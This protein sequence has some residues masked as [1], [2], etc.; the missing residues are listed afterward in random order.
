VLNKK[1]LTMM[2][3]IVGIILVSV[4][5][6]CGDDGDNGTLDGNS[7]TNGD[8][9]N[10]D[11]TNGNKIVTGTFTLT[12]IPLQYNGYAAEFDAGITSGLIKTFK[13]FEILD[14]SKSNY[15]PVPISNGS[16]SIP[17]WVSDPLFGPLPYFDDDTVYLKVSIFKLETSTIKEKVAESSVNRITFSD[18]SAV[19]SWNDF[20]WSDL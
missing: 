12:D 10:D 13:G 11:Q 5:T 14:Y 4:F 15:T 2:A 19:K 16:V 18:G 17:V 20:K 3:T 8:N 6:A 7:Q 9:G 1:L